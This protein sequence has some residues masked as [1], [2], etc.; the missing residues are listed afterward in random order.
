MRRQTLFQDPTKEKCQNFNVQPQNAV[1]HHIS[2]ISHI[3][4][5]INALLLMMIS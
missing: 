5:T 3:N 4:N 1:M 2:H